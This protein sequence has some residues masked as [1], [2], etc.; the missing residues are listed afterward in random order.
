MPKGN[1]KAAR[2]AHVGSR[3]TG[4]PE[5][6]PGQWGNDNELTPI[7]EIAKYVEQQMSV[8]AKK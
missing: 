5:D 2:K 6:K 4:D 3:L 1:G 8:W 7:S